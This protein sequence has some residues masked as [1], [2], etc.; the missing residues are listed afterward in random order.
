MTRDILKIINSL[1]DKHVFVA[2]NEVFFHFTKK[3]KKKIKTQHFNK[4]SGHC[5]VECV[6]NMDLQEL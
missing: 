4:C 6:L 1:K 2:K 3:K 5:I